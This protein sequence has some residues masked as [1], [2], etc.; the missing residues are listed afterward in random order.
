MQ[1]YILQ[2]VLLNLLVIFMVATLVFL[3]LRID[4][5][6]VVT[7]QAAQTQITD[8]GATERARDIVRADLGLDG[9]IFVQYRTYLW[10]ISHLD[11]GESFAAREDVID[12]IGNRIGP[13]LELGLLQIMVALLVAVPIGIISAIRQDTVIDYVLRFFSIALLGIPVFVLGVLVL[14]LVARDPIGYTPPLTTYRDLLPFPPFETGRGVD[15]WVNLQIMFMPAIIGGLGTGAIIMRFLRS[16]MLEVMRQDYVRTAWSKGLQER[17][18]ILRHALKNALIPVLTVVGLLLG[19]L[20]S[21]NVVL[22]TIFVIPGIG[23][24]VVN[25]IGQFDYPVIQGV[26]LVI[27]VILVFVNLLVDISYAWLD[28]RIRFG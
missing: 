27:A 1:Q 7:Q 11:L 10:N 26:V 20:V 22:E 14:L 8:P 3:V 21:A 13:S 15:V 6:F 28:P 4:T 12:E 17:V 2:R 18:I 23:L 9:S 19:T 5:D 16:Q 24:W 25:A